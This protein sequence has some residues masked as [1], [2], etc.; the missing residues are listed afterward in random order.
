MASDRYDL[1]TAH[2]PDLRFRQPLLKKIRADDLRA[3]IAAIER[4]RR[5][6]GMSH[7]TLCAAAGVHIQTWH[8]ARAGG[9]TLQR[10]ILE[11]E[12]AIAARPRRRPVASLDA[13]VRAIEAVLEAAIAADPVVLAAA[14]YRRLRNTAPAGMARGRLRTLA[15]YV[16][17]VELGHRQADLARALG[18]S[19]ANVSKACRTIEGVADDPLVRD[20]IARTATQM[21]RRQ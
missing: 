7:T 5:L 19:R 3:R 18:I 21:E 10:T 14:T 12:R 17:A 4:R 9:A 20:L 16:A 8:H 2:P 11:L 15:L 6:A 13:I 1:S